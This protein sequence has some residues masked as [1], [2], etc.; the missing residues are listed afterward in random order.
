M[1]EKTKKIL[2]TGANGFVGKH[3]LNALLQLD[4]VFVK[5]VS[6]KKI[7][8]TAN[9]KLSIV[10]PLDLLQKNGWHHVLADCDVLIHTAARVHV[11]HETD[12]DPLQAFRAVNVEGTLH[13]ARQAA[14][15]GVKRFIFISTIFVN[16]E[17]T[18]TETPFTAEDNPK[19][20]SPYGVSKYEA[21]EALKGLGWKT[22]MEIVIIRPPLIYGSGV[23]GN[24]Q[25][26]INI[27][28]KGIPLPLGAVKNKRS[29][30]AI[31]NLLSLIITCIDHPNAANELFLV[32][33]GHDLS[34]TELLQLMANALH[35][36]IHLFTIPEKILY[37][38][39]TALG[40]KAEFQRLFGSLQVDIKKTCNLLEWR[41]IV[42]V[43][44]G[45]SQLLYGAIT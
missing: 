19:P 33:D 17:R 35:K 4:D 13:L 32:S 40:K 45:F 21:E 10:P 23:K 44:Q 15:C 16:G 22:G 8:L 38:G 14:Q 26:L 6:R 31:D 34:T 7:E 25:R 1:G 39:A 43:E 12:A 11:M 37:L 18:L 28:Q 29:F 41:P 20:C 24:V 5:A 42:S 27:I 2:I 3:L 9:D 30:V 36:H